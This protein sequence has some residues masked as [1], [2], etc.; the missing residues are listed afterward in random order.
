MSE[1]PPA[2][3]PAA[4]P[5]PTTPAEGAPRSSAAIFAPLRLIRIAITGVLMGVANLIPGVSGGTM[6][7][8]MGFYEEFVGSV[9][10]LTRLRFTRRRVVFLAV[11]IPSA[12]I[13]IFG[14]ATGILYLL[15]HYP[16]A[17]FALFI[18]LTLGGAPV[19][20]TMLRPVRSDVI[21]AAVIG[22]LAMIGVRFLQQAGLPHNTGMDVVSGVIGATTMVLPGVSGSYMLLVLDQYDRVIGSIKAL[23]D[24]L[25]GRDMAVVREALQIIVPVGIGAIVGVIGLSNLLKWLLRHYHRA[26][27]GVLLGVLLGSVI[28]LWPFGRQP[29][30]EALENR[31]VAELRAFAETVGLPG[32]E[33][34][35]DDP[36]ALV[37]FISDEEIWRDRET[38]DVTLMTGVGALALVMVGFTV[39]Y[40]MGRASSRV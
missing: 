22:L 5:A 6:I 18:G 23:K 11:L 28:G 13:A 34:V 19:L 27:V 17:M 24:G 21:I 40:V 30:E 38:T 32:R 16:A 9:A 15:F 37:A 39:T 4:E 8:A 14:L 36:N 33:G 31:T 1:Q 26:T 10:D 20:V 25:S 35:A 7:L 3:R 12:V 29:S 2:E